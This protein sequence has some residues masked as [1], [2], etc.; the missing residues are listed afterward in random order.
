MTTHYCP[1]CAHA[2][3]GGQYECGVC[4]SNCTY[5]GPPVMENPMYDSRIVVREALPP[6]PAVTDYSGLCGWT[7]AEVEVKHG[8]DGVCGRCNHRAYCHR[9]AATGEQR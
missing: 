5:Q 8:K 4:R 6:C 2:A 7:A 1:K 3:H 9:S